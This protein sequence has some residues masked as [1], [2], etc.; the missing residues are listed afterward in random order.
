MCVAAD[1]WSPANI[2]TLFAKWQ[3]GTGTSDIAYAL[4]I[5]SASSG[6]LN[7]CW[8]DVGGG[9]LKEL[10]GSSLSGW[11]ADGSPC[12]IKMNFVVDTGSGMAV[13]LYRQPA[14]A[15]EEGPPSS[16]ATHG[17]A[18]TDPAAAQLAVNSQPLWLGLRSTTNDPFFGKYYYFE[19]RKGNSTDRSS[20]FWNLVNPE[21][22]ALMD[23]RFSDPTGP[24]G[25]GNS[26]SLASNAVWVPPEV[27]VGVP[28]NVVATPLSPTSI[29]VTWD[30]V[31][32][33]DAYDVERDSVVIAEKITEAEY[34]DEGLTPDTEYTYRVR[35]AKLV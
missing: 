12:W 34:T 9:G 3:G 13:R 27:T 28:Q 19:L 15:P 33:A 1:D 5:H 2:M 18:M 8:G 4:R 29:R 20:Q 35:A 32:D 22:V 14:T 23:A 17:S 25:F 7:P 11:V 26:W 24:D 16:W 31:V 6:I 30:P 10:Y 21:T